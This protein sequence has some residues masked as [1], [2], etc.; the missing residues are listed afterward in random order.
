MV[1]T[2]LEA[3]SKTAL[4]VVE[5]TRSRPQLPGAEHPIIGGKLHMLLTRSASDC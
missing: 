1:H 4:N 5:K 2:S 3:Q